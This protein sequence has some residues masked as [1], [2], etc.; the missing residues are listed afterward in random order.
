MT[1]QGARR[2]AVALGGLLVAMAAGLSLGGCGSGGEEAEGAMTTTTRATTPESSTTTSLATRTATVTVSKGASKTVPGC[3]TSTCH[4]VTV[5]VADM[6]P[7]YQVQCFSAL[8]NAPYYA[9]TTSD[10]TSDVC[11]FGYTRQ[12]VWVV[13]NGVPSNRITW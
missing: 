5:A 1:G 2:R 7:G 3:N 6:A 12:S 13:V 10:T 4:S 11:V 9:Y 8:D